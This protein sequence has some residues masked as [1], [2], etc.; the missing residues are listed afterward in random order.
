MSPVVLAV[1]VILCTMAIIAVCAR[2]IAKCCSRNSCKKNKTFPGKSH[3]KL[4][5]K[6]T[7]EEVFQ[8]EVDSQEA[9]LPARNSSAHPLLPKPQVKRQSKDQYSRKKLIQTEDNCKLMNDQTTIEVDPMLPNP[10]VNYKSP[11]KTKE[12]QQQH[13]VYPELPDMLEEVCQVQVKSSKEIQPGIFHHIQQPPYNNTEEQ[14]SD[15][16]QVNSQSKDKPKKQMQTDDNSKLMNNPTTKA[17]TMDKNPLFP[18]VPN[19]KLNNKPP[20]MSKVQV[21]QVDSNTNLKWNFSIYLKILFFKCN[22]S[23]TVLIC[24][25]T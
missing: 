20:A 24:S 21:R 10:K 2:Q 17:M 18:M 5:G 14:D 13:A 15:C 19:P 23:K 1:I 16:P 6:E 3:Y 12:C 8:V 25:T 4:V 9:L 11:A 22:R 7:L